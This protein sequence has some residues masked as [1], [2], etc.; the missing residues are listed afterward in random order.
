MRKCREE[1]CRGRV[2]QGKSII[3]L[4]CRMLGVCRYCYNGMFP[5]HGR[6]YFPNPRWWVN[7]AW[8]KVFTPEERSGWT[9]DINDGD[10]QD[11]GVGAVLPR[12]PLIG[13]EQFPD[14]IVGIR[15]S[16]DIPPLRVG[17]SNCP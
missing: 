1:L 9:P 6:Q 15:D 11:A 8:V 3:S 4:A 14:G 7:H 5:E 16:K 2:P 10:G 12:Q 17:L 13:S